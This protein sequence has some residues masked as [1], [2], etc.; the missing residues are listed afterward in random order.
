MTSSETVESE[1]AT[2]ASICKGVVKLVI[3]SN[4][5]DDVESSYSLVTGTRLREYPDCN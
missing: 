1:V 4:G 2:F 3:D 5:N